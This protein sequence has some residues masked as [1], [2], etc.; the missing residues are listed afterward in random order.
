ML[1]SDWLAKPSSPAAT[2]YHAGRISLLVPKRRIIAFPALHYPHLHGEMFWKVIIPNISP[3]HWIN[4]KG[5][6][7]KNLHFSDISTGTKRPSNAS[8]TLIGHAL[9][10]K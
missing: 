7:N 5:L 8:S 2:I 6:Y 3:S 10:V 1:S 4:K 9:H